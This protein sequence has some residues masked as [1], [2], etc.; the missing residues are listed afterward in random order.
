MKSDQLLIIY[1]QDFVLGV[2]IHSSIALMSN[3][4]VRTIVIA[5]IMLTITDTHVLNFDIHYIV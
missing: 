3:A 2:K 1:K 4:I 5:N